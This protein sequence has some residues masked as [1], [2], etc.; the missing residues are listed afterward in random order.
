[1]APTPLDA[2]ASAAEISKKRSKRKRKDE[3]RKRHVE[4]PTDHLMS[5]DEAGEQP[6]EIKSKKRRREPDLE[7]ALPAATAGDSCSSL[8]PQPEPER[9]KRKKLKD[10]VDSPSQPSAQSNDDILRM[11]QTA[12]VSKIN[13]EGLLQAAGLHSTASSR[14]VS[15]L[16]RDV[17]TANRDNAQAPPK[18]T[19]KVSRAG[20]STREKVAEKKLLSSA[21][22]SQSNLPAVN[23]SPV[24]PTPHDQNTDEQAHALATTWFTPRQLEAKIKNEGLLVRKGKFSATERKAAYDAMERFCIANDITEEQKIELISTTAKSKGGLGKSFWRE[25]TIAVPQRS[26]PAVYHHVTRA[27][28]PHRHQGAWTADED[29]AILRAVTAYGFQ[30]QKVA[31]AVGR[32]GEDCRDRYRNHLALANKASGKWSQQE[33]EKLRTIVESMTA[34]S[35]NDEIFWTEVS[36]QFGTRTRQQCHEKW[37]EDLA[38]RKDEGKIQWTHHDSKKLVKLLRS[39]KV[40]DELDVDWSQISVGMNSAWTTNKCRKQWRKLRRAADPGNEKTYT[41]A[42]KLVRRNIKD[43]RD[44]DEEPAAQELATRK[45]KKTTAAATLA[46]NVGEISSA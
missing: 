10:I 11:L 5:V 29:A 40:G 28:H 17:D 9:K 41:E 24:V 26:L 4:P 7:I 36:K 22:N 15:K 35:N 3:Q 20:K 46:K 32:T 14:V 30:W 34:N 6:T 45:R 43:H 21:S 23:S 38:I 44:P 18:T 37:R 13:L 33:E 31:A 12:D 39:I 8:E 19:K 1:M 27:Y 42:L 2:S 25:I 16:Q